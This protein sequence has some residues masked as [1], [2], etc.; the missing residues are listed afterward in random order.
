MANIEMFDIDDNT[1]IDIIVE[2]TETNNDDEIF[3]DEI[4]NYLAYNTDYN[5]II[6]EY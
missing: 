5:T 4:L 1:I 6:D 2:E 3:D